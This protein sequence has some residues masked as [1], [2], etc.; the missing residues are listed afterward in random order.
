MGQFSWLGAG[1]MPLRLD[2]RL[3]GWELAP[4]PADTAASAHPLLLDDLSRAV[5]LRNPKVRARV[6][7]TDIADPLT[8]AHLLALGFGDVMGSDSTLEEVGLRARRVAWAVATLPRRRSHGPV[9]LDLLDREGWVGRHRLGLHPREFALLWRLA[10]TP[11]EPVA[12][13]TLLSEVWH[14]SHR[15]ETNSLAVHVCRLRAKLAVAGLPHLL[16]TSPGGY[17][18][19]APDAASQEVGQSGDDEPGP[20]AGRGPVGRPAPEPA[21]AS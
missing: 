9:I 17:V 8:R 21:A 14:L 4:I 20:G 18:L 15:P 5:A 6:V 12:P 2:L 1:Q 10:E 13:D 3:L 16:C 7:V 11:D 19:R